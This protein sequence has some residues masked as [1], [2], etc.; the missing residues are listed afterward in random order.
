MVVSKVQLLTRRLEPTARADV[1][2][3][4]AHQLAEALQD[5]HA[6]EEREGFVARR[7]A[8]VEALVGG[9]VQVLEVGGGVRVAAADARIAFGKSADVFTAADLMSRVTRQF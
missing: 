5:D 7:E 1:W 6:A 4:V 8:D 3:R 2:M 9:L